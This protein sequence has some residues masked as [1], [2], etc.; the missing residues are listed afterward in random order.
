MRELPKYVVRRMKMSSAVAGHPEAD[1]LAAFA[2]RSL[3]EGERALL[4]EHLARCGD[5]REVVALAAPEVDV[6]VEPVRTGFP[7]RRWWQWPVLRGAAVAAIVLAIG[8]VIVLEHRHHSPGEVMVSRTAQPN[9][10]ATNSV[11]A[12]KAASPE[13][14]PTTSRPEASSRPLPGT[15]GASDER[16]KSTGSITGSGG[17]IGSRATSGQPT[18]MAMAEPPRDLAFATS[19][20]SLSLRPTKQLPAPSVVVPAAPP[21]SSQMVKVEGPSDATVADHSPQLEAQNTGSQTSPDG[22]DNVRKAKPAI[23]VAGTAVG[24]PTVARNAI[25]LQQVYQTPAPKWTITANGGLQRS[26]DGGKTWQNVYVNAVAASTAS[27]MQLVMP[28]Q[29]G[30][31]KE[32]E[33]EKKVLKD[34]LTTAPAAAPVF[35]AVAAMGDEVW[36]GGSGGLLYHSLDAGTLWAAVTPSAQGVT[37]SGDVV[38]IEFS[39]SQHG[40]IT[41]STSEIWTTANGGKS[42]DKQ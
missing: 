34:R 39:D 16:A 35:R 4:L 42:W 12:Q 19:P 37:L 11:P 22:S 25:D 20:K 5:C 23:A 32:K 38:G 30:A 18:K 27:S 29:N 13:V 7:T 21:V 9:Q 10:V 36:A 26:L 28:S 24:G 2:E 33:N 3:P 14:T 41:S 31:A 1:V 15:A 8:S 40:K 6:H 17:G